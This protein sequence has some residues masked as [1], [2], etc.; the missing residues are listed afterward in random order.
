MLDGLTSKQIQDIDAYLA[1]NNPELFSF[2]K[3]YGPEGNVIGMN[4]VPVDYEAYRN[5]YNERRQQ[6]DDKYNNAL[7]ELTR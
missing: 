7:E 6:I 2:Q 3:V 1:D 5:A 4:R